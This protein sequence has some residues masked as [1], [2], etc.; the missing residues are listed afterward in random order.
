MLMEEGLLLVIMNENNMNHY[1]EEEEI[2][3]KLKIKNGG[4][5]KKYIKQQKNMI[6]AVQRFFLYCSIKKNR[7]YLSFKED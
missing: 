6:V 5:F 4:V 1:Y 2:Y 3:R 7:R